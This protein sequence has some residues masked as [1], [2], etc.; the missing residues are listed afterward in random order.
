L[1]VIGVA[2]TLELVVNTDAHEG[3]VY[4]PDT[5]E[6]YFASSRRKL[7]YLASMTSDNKVAHAGDANTEV[8][9]AGAPCTS[10]PEACIAFRQLF[11]K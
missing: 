6:F 11:S 7:G 2:P 9:V 1:E 8:H 10:R 5:N 4:F 3:G